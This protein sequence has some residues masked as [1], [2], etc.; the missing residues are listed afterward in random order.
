MIYLYAIGAANG[1]VLAA[2]LLFKP[3]LGGASRVMA[4]WCLLL[5]VNFLGNFVYTDQAL[6]VLSFLIGWSYFLPAAYGGLLYLYCKKLL[7]HTDFHLRDCLHFLPLLFCYA[8]NIDILLAPSELKL[9]YIL[10]L[11]PQTPSFFISQFIL[12]AQALVYGVLSIVLLI[13]YKQ[14]YKQ[15][16]SNTNSGLSYW[17]GIIIGLTFIIWL[18]K[19]SA[20]LFQNAN[21][22]SHLGAALIVLLIYSV[23]FMHWL[24]PEWFM[25]QKLIDLS[26]H[27]SD[28][29]HGSNKTK[30]SQGVRITLDQSTHASLAKILC[31]AVKE[32]ALYLRGD[33]SLA[34]LSA[35]TNISVHHIS[36]TLNYYLDKNFYRFINEYRVA[37]FC[38]QLSLAIDADI[39]PK[40]THLAMDAGFSNKSTFNAAFKDLKHITPSQFRAQLKKEN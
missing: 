31:D 19:F 39:Q 21:W 22:L 24:K 23:G 1:L 3:A 40:I 36:E 5:S 20:S 9:S 30:N 6:N 26:E 15:Q 33:L 14:N 17:M 2:L 28:K 16:Y 18:A 4:L 25:T 35:E 27:A 37:H 34:E 12:F 13:Q 32:K 7:D 38:E 29:D 10:N 8:L 11:P